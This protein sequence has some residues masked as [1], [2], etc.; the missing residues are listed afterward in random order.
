MK[1]KHEPI[2]F[3]QRENKTFNYQSRLSKDNRVDSDLETLNQK[4]F[5]SKWKQGGERKTGRVMSIRTLIFVL[6]VLLICM[7]LLEKKYM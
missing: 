3:K 2:L 6:V 5:A 7:Y 1:D 4:E